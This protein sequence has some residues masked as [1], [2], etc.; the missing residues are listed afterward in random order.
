MTDTQRSILAQTGYT[1]EQIDSM[2]PEQRETE[3]E[4]AIAA[5]IKPRIP[6]PARNPDDILRNFGFSDDQIAAMSPQERA[7]WVQGASDIGVGQPPVTPEGAPT[8]V[9]KDFGWPIWPF[10]LLAGIGLT[11]TY[12]LTASSDLR[13]RSSRVELDPRWAALGNCTNVI[14]F[15]GARELTVL[16]DK[17]ATVRTR[18][19]EGAADP[20]QDA[21]GSWSFNEETGQ[22]AIKIGTTESVYSLISIEPANT[23][24]LIKGTVESANLSG[25]WFSL[26]DGTP[27]FDPGPD[28]RM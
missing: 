28:N 14:S 2:S 13:P 6:A 18:L 26:P 4:E 25:S 5:G 12:W 3:V 15:D 17:T 23:C 24:M 8:P 21:H 16:S 27:E 10:V 22:Y 11:V 1:T 19:K 7:G 20:P 9:Y